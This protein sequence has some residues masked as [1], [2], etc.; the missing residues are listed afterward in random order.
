VD[1]VRVEAIG[2][3][4]VRFAAWHEAIERSY[5]D[6]REPGWWESLAATRIYFARTGGQKRHVA[7][8]ASV[9]DDVAGGAELG[10][11]LDADLE[12]MSV[13]LGVLPG[14]RRQGIG[15]ALLSAVR[16]VA[17]REARDVLQAEVFVPT[18]VAVEQWPGARFAERHGLRCATVE[19]R[20]L[21]D[22]P[23][24]SERLDALAAAADAA[25]SG[26]DAI[27]SWVGACPEEHVDQWARMK[28]QMNQDVPTGELTITARQVDTQR[29]RD[30]DR[31]M[32]QQGWTKVRSMALDGD[33]TGRG[34]TEL[35]VSEHDHDVV[36]QDDT[37]V[38]RSQ[39]GRRLGMRLKVAN[40]RQL[41]DHDGGALLGSRRSAQTYCE[42][43]NTAMRRINADVGFREVDTLRGYE[44]P[45]GG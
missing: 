6:G 23:V 42:Q 11:P 4:D 19:H 30:S 29:V 10:L 37:W 16:D 25:A 12:T 8:V 45:V 21:L 5:A 36:V 20:F 14:A 18:G 7:L 39:R 1:E 15:S 32:A 17:A 31:R 9:G 44:G 27:V 41:Q 22:L 28:T 40:L 34:Y 26:K 33:G 2:P 3:D 13:E 43:D 38:D 24:P 35:F